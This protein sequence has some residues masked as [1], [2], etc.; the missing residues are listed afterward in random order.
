MV[1]LRDVYGL[2]HSAIAEELGISRAAAKVRLHR[3]R[4]KLRDLLFPPSPPTRA[5]V[6]DG[7][8]IVALTRGDE[9]RAA[10]V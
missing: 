1:V 10:V 4:R 6:G 7:A 9:D 2:S 3:G 8:T 5:G